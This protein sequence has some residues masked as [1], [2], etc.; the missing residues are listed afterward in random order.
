ML[1]GGKLGGGGG[2][3]HSSSP[4]WREVLDADV[5]ESVK[6]IHIGGC[7]GF[8]TFKSCSRGFVQVSRVWQQTVAIAVCR[9]SLVAGEVLAD[10]D[11]SKSLIQR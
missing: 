1:L 2:R 6:L 11:R 5:F 9:G 4:F 8:L 10:E 7:V 3:A